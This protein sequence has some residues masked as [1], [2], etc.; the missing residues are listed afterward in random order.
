MAM[1]KWIINI[2]WCFLLSVVPAACSNVTE[3]DNLSVETGANEE[4]TVSLQL[5]PSALQG[6]LTEGTRSTDSFSAD[7]ENF[8]FD[9]WVLQFN[10]MGILI[11]STYVD[12]LG[13]VTSVESLSMNLRKATDCTVCVVANTGDANA[14]WPES[15]VSF[16]SMNYAFE[17][18]SSV[19]QIPM[20]GIYIGDVTENTSIHM[21][22]GRLLNRINVTLMREEGVDVLQNLTVKLINI[23]KWIRPYPATID[24]TVLT[25]N[26]YYDSDVIPAFYT[27]AV[28]YVGTVTSKKTSTTYTAYLYYYLPA[29]ICE[30]ELFATTLEILNQS[31]EKIYSIVL[32]E[33]S[34]GTTDRSYR[35]YANTIYNFTL[36]LK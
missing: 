33:D 1:K 21:I 20:S 11:R 4:V 16:K 9:V 26:D 35:L 7:I 12:G 25:P 19:T 29:N 2:G 13:G 3:E 22:L 24:A 5:Q 32:G 15:L 6:T 30:K 14:S 18:S 28:E 27:D 8:L 10:N 36:T 31:G 23:P 17:V 34:P